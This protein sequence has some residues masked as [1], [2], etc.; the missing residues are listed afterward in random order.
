MK[1]KLGFQQRSVIDRIT[2]K[3]ETQGVCFRLT[4]KWAAVTL[5]GSYFNSNPNANKTA[6]KHSQYRDDTLKIEKRLGGDFSSNDEMLAYIETDYLASRAFAEKW[7]REFTTYGSDEKKSGK[8]SIKVLEQNKE[9]ISD[10]I[11]KADILENVAIL[12][13]FYGRKTDGKVWGHVV[14]FCTNGGKSGYGSFFDSNAGLY[15][16]ESGEDRAEAIKDWIKRNYL[17]DGRTITN[18]NTIVLK[19]L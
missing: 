2:A 18:Y 5:V 6:T 4:F 11:R 13:G 9:P 8:A 7:S 3:L 19:D 14:A 17:K 16:F 12:A 1:C 10:Y 15:D